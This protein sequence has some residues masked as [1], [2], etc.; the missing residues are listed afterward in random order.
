[1]MTTTGTP[2]QKP[3]PRKLKSLG[4]RV[5]WVAAGEHLHDPA[6]EIH[7]AQGQPDDEG[8]GG[9]AQQVEDVV[10]VEEHRVDD[11]HDDEQQHKRYR[12]AQLAILG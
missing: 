2:A 5:D 8:E 6:G 9:L 3:W 4:Q 11:S 10:Q 1:M 7:H 12:D